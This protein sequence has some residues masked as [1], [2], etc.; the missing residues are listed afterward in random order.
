MSRTFLS[1]KALNLR[2]VT[3]V[4]ARD[5]QAG[6]APVLTLI[7]LAIAGASLVATLMT[8]PEFRGYFFSAS[9]PKASLGT[10]KP[11]AAAPSSPL[12]TFAPN[13]SLSTSQASAPSP[14]RS[15]MPIPTALPQVT[16]AASASRPFGAASKS[17][18]LGM[19]QQWQFRQEHFQEN[20]ESI[21][22][23]MEEKDCEYWGI[24]AE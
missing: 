3:V 5:C 18:C 9:E 1:K 21:K 7:G 11:D 10:T 16:G 6:E 12:Q 8:V 19:K 13:P 20:D 24:R 14:R 15:V 23:A 17:W 4:Q 2:S 22:A